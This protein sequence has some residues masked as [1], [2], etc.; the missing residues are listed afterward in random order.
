MKISWAGSLQN[1]K[2]KQ[3]NIASYDKLHIST[4]LD[5]AISIFRLR[6][7]TFDFTSLLLSRNI[8]TTVQ[9]HWT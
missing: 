9:H 7:L 1:H 6:S 4:F 5:N 2:K 3:K 8:P